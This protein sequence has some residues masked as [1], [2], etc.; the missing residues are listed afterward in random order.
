MRVKY[1]C[2]P[3]QVCGLTLLG[4]TLCVGTHQDHGSRA[5]RRSERCMAGTVSREIHGVSFETGVDFLGCNPLLFLPVRLV[6]P[7]ASWIARS[8]RRAVR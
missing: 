6:S 2:R 8:S 1:A 5:G 4:A 3:T 7:V